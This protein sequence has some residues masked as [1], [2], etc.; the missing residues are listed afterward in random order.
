MLALSLP[1][2]S[3]AD[4]FSYSYIFGEKKVGHLTAATTADL[5]TVDYDVKNNGRGPTIA[6]KIKLDAA[7]WP[8][9]W[10]INGSTTFGSKIAEHYSRK[11]AH[12]EWLDSTG[13][14]HATI[15]K[16]RAST[17]RRA[18]V[19]GQMASTLARS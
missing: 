8:I 17:W 19:L 4:T 11:G 13:K 16:S 10:S 7:G 18:P 9:E 6:E 14:G 1:A 5:T 3:L 2:S 12:C 15:R